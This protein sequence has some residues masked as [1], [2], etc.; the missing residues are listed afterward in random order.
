[1]TVRPEWTAAIEAS[2]RFLEK[3]THFDAGRD[4]ISRS[5][6]NGAWWQMSALCE[7]GE[8]R[9]IP[10][11][12]VEQARKLLQTR[13]WPRFVIRAED[14]P[15]RPEDLDRWD[16]CHCE[17][18]VFYRVLSDCGCDP[19]T[20]MP[21]IREWLLSYQ[22]PDGGLNCD[23]DAYLHFR[24]SSI[25]ST[26]PPLEA[27][28]HHTRRP[29]TQQE[30]HFLDEGARYLINHKLVCA[31]GSG[32]VINEEWLKPC[33][34]RFFEYDLLR[35]LNY[36]TAW[37]RKREQTLPDGFAREA[38][39][40]IRP[41]LDEDGDGGYRVRIG[42]QVWEADGEWGGETFELLEALPG[43]GEISDFLN[44]ES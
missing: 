12:A 41:Y 11:I 20:D 38:L 19:D 29:F 7:M 13:V 23:P 3:T 43:I 21:W 9:R 31:S 34:P 44:I 5:K 14:A 26:L 6:W 4:E 10:A 35:G 42:R 28:L 22:L 17:L 8:A 36:L 40:R 39:E 30:Q 25:V 15:S 18:A 27:I 2:V 1:M 33:F 24:K 37:S 32:R 16:C